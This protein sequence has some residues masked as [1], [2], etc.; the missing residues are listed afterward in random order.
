M[1]EFEKESLAFTP[2]P[3]LKPLMVS[4]EVALPKSS[5]RQRPEPSERAEQRSCQRGGVGSDAGS[6]GGRACATL[7]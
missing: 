4:S 7:T 6:A 1:K 2:G 5:C 3:P